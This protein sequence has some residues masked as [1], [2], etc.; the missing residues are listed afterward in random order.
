MNENVVLCTIL[1]L[2]NFIEVINK[3]LRRSFVTLPEIFTVFANRLSEELRAR[4][5]CV[6]KQRPCTTRALPK[7]HHPNDRAASNQELGFPETSHRGNH[8]Q[9]SPKTQVK[10][11]KLHL[12]LNWGELILSSKDKPTSLLCDFLRLISKELVANT[13][14]W[15]LMQ[16]Q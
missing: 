6:T 16:T 5:T 15:D 8:A 12:L 2:R 11:T 4:H 1:V 7:R 14:F 13:R 3:T 10:Q 9:L